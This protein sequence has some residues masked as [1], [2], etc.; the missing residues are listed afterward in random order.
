MR[1]NFLS[2][3]R[4]VRLRKRTNPMFTASKCSSCQHE[5][6]TGDRY[7]INA[8]L[9]GNQ[10]RTTYDCDKCD[11]GMD[12]RGNWFIYK[13][14]DSQY[15][16][17]D[18]CYASILVIDEKVLKPHHCFVI[19]KRPEDPQLFDM[20]LDKH[21][22]KRLCFKCCRRIKKPA[23]GVIWNAYRLSSFKIIK[24]LI[25]QPKPERFKIEQSKTDYIIYDNLFHE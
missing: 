13:T 20:D 9:S 15:K 25:G 2:L 12:R 10:L 24:I 23:H 11:P 14:I 6:K 22:G 7:A 1:T 4:L 8:R 21:Y 19:I 5:F 18:K 17:C 16:R 3:N